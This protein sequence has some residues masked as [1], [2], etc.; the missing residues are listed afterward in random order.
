MV[1]VHRVPSA[2]VESRGGPARSPSTYRTGRAERQSP[3]RGTG[4]AR[5]EQAA[6][7]AGQAKGPERPG[8]ARSAGASL[9]ADREHTVRVLLDDT[10]AARD[11]GE[12]LLGAFGAIVDQPELRELEVSLVGSFSD[13]ALRDEIEFAVERWRFVCRRQGALVVVG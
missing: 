10:A 8:L 12:F 9:L 1:L 5:L 6:R 11:L 2:A 3:D 4:E 13:A 7:G